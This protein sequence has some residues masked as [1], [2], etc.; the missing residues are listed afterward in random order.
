M[1]QVGGRAAEEGEERRAVA[2]HDAEAGERHDGQAEDGG[3][4]WRRGISRKSTLG[5]LAHF[6]VPRVFFFRDFEDQNRGL[7]DRAIE[8]RRNVSLTTVL[9][10]E[11]FGCYHGVPRRKLLGLGTD[12][13]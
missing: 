9:K 11:L 7:H 5:E 6:V 12:L 4:A 8:N 1:V 2:G 10:H 13:I 3:H